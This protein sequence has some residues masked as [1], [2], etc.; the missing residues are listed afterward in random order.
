[1]VT[2]SNVVA[3]PTTYLR[4]GWAGPDA[5]REYSESRLTVADTQRKLTSRGPKS[6]LEWRVSRALLQDMQAGGNTDASWSL[7]HSAGHALC[8]YDPG[9][10]I[11]GVDLEFMRPRK[12]LDLAE[13][14]C[15]L[16]E[17]QSLQ[18]LNEK[19]RLERFYLLWTVKEALVKAAGLRFPEDMPA[20]GLE[21]GASDALRLR[22]PEGIWQVWAY[23]LEPGW[24]AAVAWSGP[25]EVKIVWHAGP[26]TALPALY[27]LGRWICVDRPDL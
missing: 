7:S 8:G 27:L 17:L 4:V 16:G 1:M 5:G 15:N 23:T 14:V 10:G 25:D 9:G 21:N 24:V 20:V 22:A 3:A 19:D 13:W 11:L 2:K 12:V 6:A 26:H 18:E